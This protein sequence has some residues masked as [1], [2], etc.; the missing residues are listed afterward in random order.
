MTD[1]PQDPTQ[2]GLML[3]EVVENQ[4]KS[5]EPIETTKTLERLM[6]LGEGPVFVPNNLA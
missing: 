2:E 3:I 6:A 5:G 4:I 1:L